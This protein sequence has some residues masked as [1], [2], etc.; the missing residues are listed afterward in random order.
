MRQDIQL[1]AL[2]NRIAESAR[3]AGLDGE[4]GVEKN[5]KVCSC[6]KLVLCMSLTCHLA[7]SP[8]GSRMVGCG[9]VAK[10]KL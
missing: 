2:K 1:E 5:I 7:C 4:M 10:Q 3:K 9:I 6:L 8:S